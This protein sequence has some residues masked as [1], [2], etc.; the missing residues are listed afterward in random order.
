MFTIFYWNKLNIDNCIHRGYENKHLLFLYIHMLFCSMNSIEVKRK[1]GKLERSRGCFGG[2]LIILA[3]L[4]PISAIAQISVI[5]YGKQNTWIRSEGKGYVIPRPVATLL[6]TKGEFSQA[7][8][9]E[10]G[11]GTEIKEI[12]KNVDKSFNGQ[13]YDCILAFPASF[14]YHERLQTV[15]L[16]SNKVAKVRINTISEIAALGYNHYHLTLDKTKEQY[17]TKVFVV[18]SDQA[19]SATIADLGYL[20]VVEVHGSI[21]MRIASAPVVSQAYIDA[22][23]RVLEMLSQLPETRDYPYDE[24]VLSGLNDLSAIIGGLK[25]NS[26]IHVPVS[27]FPKLVTKG[28][29]TQGAISCGSAEAKDD[30]LLVAT[31]HSSFGI[32][33]PVDASM[34]EV[35]RVSVN[36]IN[37]FQDAK[38]SETSG[39]ILGGDVIEMK[40][41]LRLVPQGSF[42]EVVSPFT[43]IPSHQ[44]IEVNLFEKP[45]NILVA[46][47][48]GKSVLPI[49]RIPWNQDLSVA[50]KGTCFKIS[51]DVNSNM[52]MEITIKDVKSAMAFKYP[53]NFGVKQDTPSDKY[54]PLR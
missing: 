12:F 3:V 53:V 43:T 54:K 29:L 48:T 37:L 33:L 42:L 25:A 6:R 30:L 26:R 24:I 36:A 4:F 16:L 13:S 20:G 2:V 40:E 17:T 28:L 19:I 18:L 32:V 1:S 46:E 49:L 52:L 15:Q 50:K 23:S 22:I 14:S 5:C 11:G 31:P 38:E 8:S 47:Y 35:T 27:G 10:L 9:T 34:T 44:T 21:G 41:D 39:G 45:D 7:L 51:I